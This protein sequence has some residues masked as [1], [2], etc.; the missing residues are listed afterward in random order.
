[1]PAPGASRRARR[2]GPRLQPQVATPTLNP[3]LEK[4]VRDPAQQELLDW[5]RHLCCEFS[6]MSQA[7]RHLD[8]W[9]RHQ[10]SLRLRGSHYVLC[11]GYDGRP[12]QPELESVGDARV[13]TKH[14]HWPPGEKALVKPLDRELSAVWCEILEIDE[15]LAAIQDLRP[16]QPAV[17]ELA[18]AWYARVKS[19]EDGGLSD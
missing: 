11:F 14:C 5:R 18:A 7:R 15:A 17:K 4:K 8:A 12:G 3:R 6:V 9:D 10:W 19:L 1:M 16:R 2:P 13:L